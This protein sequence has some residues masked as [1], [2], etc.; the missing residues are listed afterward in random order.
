MVL[1]VIDQKLT[2]ELQKDGRK[3][4]VDLARKLGVVEGTVR[5]RV[6]RLLQRNMFKVVAVPNVAEL[7]YGFVAIMGLQVKMSDLRKV[8]EELSKMPEVCYLT[9]VT[10]RYDLMAVVLSKSATELSRFI[11]SK[12]STLPRIIRT[13]TF[14][15]LDIIKG[16]WPVVDTSELVTSLCMNQA[17]QETTPKR[18]RGRKAKASA[19]KA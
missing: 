18:A 15:S 10:G 19:L 16:G 13:E 5:K 3:S 4:Y 6:K 11:E 12:V 1:D 7:G 8:A 9:F 17:G 14:V 2:L